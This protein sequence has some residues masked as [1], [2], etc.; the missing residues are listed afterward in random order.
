MGQIK[1]KHRI[2]SYLI[3]HSPSEQSERASKRAN[4]Q[5]SGP[6]VQSGFLIILAHSVVSFLSPVAFGA[7]S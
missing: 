3:N 1:E 4:G 5:A 6:V 2:N 7:I